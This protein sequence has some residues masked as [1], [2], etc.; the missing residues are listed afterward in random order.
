MDVWRLP[1]YCDCW[2]CKGGKNKH[3]WAFFYFMKRRG[4]NVR[5]STGLGKIVI[6]RK[7][8]HKPQDAQRAETLD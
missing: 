5:A 4:E 3:A 1:E 6:E 7:T 2:H 8:P